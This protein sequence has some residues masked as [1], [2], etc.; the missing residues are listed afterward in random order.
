MP[1]AEP[2]DVQRPR[3]VPVRRDQAHLPQADQ[4]LRPGPARPRALRALRALHPLRRTDRRRPVHRADRARC[5]AAG[6]HLREGAVRLLLLRQH[7]PDLPGR[8]ADLRGLPLPL[9]PVRPGLDADRVRALRR[10]G[11][12]LRTDHRR[13]KVLRRLAGDDPEVNEEWNCDKGRC[14][15][16]YATADDRL[17]H[18]LVRDEDGELVPTS[19][20]EALAVAARGLAGRRQ[21]VGVLV[22]RPLTRRGRLRLRASSPA[23]RSAPTTSTSAPAR[24]PPRRPTFLAVARRRPRVVRRDVRRPRER[25]TVVLL[26]GLRARGRVADRLPAAA[27]GAPRQRAAARLRRRAVHDPRASSKLGGTVLA[28]PPGRRGRGPRR[29]SPHDGDVALDAAAARHPR[30]RAARRRPRRAVRGRRRLADADRRPARL[31]AAARR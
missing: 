6:R 28:R 24:T 14:A 18:P 21:G 9:A 2:G 26:V 29:R 10:R 15:F 13:G 7:H 5:A 30:R 22:R 19:W 20:P 23:S 27:Q 17:T 12:A 25:A 11:C 31:G 16:R 8:R 4:H 1:A 3:R